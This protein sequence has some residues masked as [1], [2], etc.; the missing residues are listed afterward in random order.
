MAEPTVWWLLVAAF[1]VLE[2]LSGT[3]YLLMLAMGTAAA[4][5]MAH[6]GG[7]MVLQLVSAACVGGGSVCAWYW[8]KSRDLAELPVQANPNVY[9][10]IG[11]V[12]QINAWNPDASATV[13]YRGAAWTVVHRVGITPTPG[14][15]R[16]VE[17]VGNRLIVEKI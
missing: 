15:H 11:E 4:A 7:G 5:I 6:A 14:M 2:L 13:Q 3:F 16:V 12:L 8:K 17:V 10:D 1:V 9:L